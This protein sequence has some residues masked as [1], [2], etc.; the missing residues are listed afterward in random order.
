MAV[1][2]STVDSAR[3][4]ALR[5][6]LIV[7]V[8]YIHARSG[9]ITFS[10]KTVAFQSDLLDAVKSAVSDGVARTAVP[11]FFLLSGYLLFYGQDTWSWSE[12]GRKLRRRVD[13]LLVPYLFWNVALFVLITCAQST[14]LRVFFSSSGIVRD[15]D[16]GGL[17]AWVLGL[18]RYPIAYQFWFI[19]DLMLLVLIG[20][21]CFAFAR[22]PAVA[23]AVTAI[24][25]LCWMADWWPV[26]V[27]AIEAL[28]FFF[29]GLA[30]GIHRR[31]LFAG[32][33]LV[34]IAFGYAGL[35]TTF[36]VLRGTTIESEIQHA[37][38]ATGIVLA[39]AV[40]RNLTPST[41]GRIAALADASFFVFAVH[42]PLT[43]ALMKISYRMLPVSSS[44]ALTIYLLVPI[45]VVAI[46]LILYRIALALAP[47]LTRHVTGR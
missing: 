16:W 1:A 14:P 3:L 9:T 34:P 27:P 40:V 21:A 37:L 43:T 17:I 30:A 22:Q 4:A 8:I 18:Q 24:L 23:I 46:T 32:P 28:L 5:F 2:I 25:G 39:L 20:P 13:T 11:L 33:P 19:R 29:I 45:I 26:T 36:L 44:M 31:N 47:S 38:V 7:L 10:D 35:L 6:P 12:F 42:E 41:L 15:I